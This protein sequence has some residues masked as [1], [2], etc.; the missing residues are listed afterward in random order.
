MPGL[1]APFGYAVLFPPVV[2]GNVNPRRIA[3]CSNADSTVEA[4]VA[5]A[6]Y[7]FSIVM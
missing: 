3:N 7:P 2:R 5:A 1:H 6:D 4:I